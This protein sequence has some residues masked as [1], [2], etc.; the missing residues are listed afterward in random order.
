MRI[1]LRNRCRKRITNGSVWLEY[2]VCGG[3]NG[4]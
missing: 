1:E 2:V 4:E 3:G